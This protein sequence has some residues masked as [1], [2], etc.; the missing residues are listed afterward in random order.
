MFIHLEQCPKHPT[1]CG[2]SKKKIQD[3]APTTSQ[4]NF[5]SD[6]IYAIQLTASEREGEHLEHQVETSEPKDELL[7]AHRAELHL[8]RLNNSSR[9]RTSR[10]PLL[11]LPQHMLMFRHL[12][13][14]AFS[15]LMKKL[16]TEGLRTT[17]KEQRLSTN[18]VVHLY[19]E[20]ISRLTYQKFHIFASHRGRYGLYQV[21]EFYT[22]YRDL[23][24]EGKKKIL[25][26]SR[27][28]MLLFGAEW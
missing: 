21:E 5:N 25:S 2:N 14:G 13:H 9:I 26:L 11:H 1:T 12:L 4:V 3:H 24:P 17:I 15:I 7:E 19:K 20:I 28:T 22:T 23:V 8:K 27:Y 18:G 6:E 10:S 16:K